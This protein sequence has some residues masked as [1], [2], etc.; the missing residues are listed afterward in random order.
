MKLIKKALGASAAFAIVALS[1]PPAR[2]EKTFHIVSPGLLW[3]VTKQLNDAPAWGALGGELTYSY[4]F[5]TRNLFMGLGAFGQAQTVGFHH[6]RAAAGPQMTF[7]LAGLEVGPYIETAKDTYATT[8]GVH[9][10]PFFTLGV[11]S[12]AFRAAIPLTTT[13]EGTRYGVDL[14]AIFTLKLPFAPGEELGHL[15]IVWMITADP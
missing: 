13:T 4:V 10:S 1:S 6:F 2:A 12:V 3:G 8:V 14:G 11:F 9:A 7:T 5:K 15:P